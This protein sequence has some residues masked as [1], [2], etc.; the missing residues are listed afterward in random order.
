MKKLLRFL[1]LA[2]CVFC[3][4]AAFAG[5]K[6]GDNSAALGFSV[7]AVAFWALARACRSRPKAAEPAPRPAAPAAEVDALARVFSEGPQ[8]AL[9]A[10]RAL[11]ALESAPDAPSATREAVERAVPALVDRGMEDDLLSEEDEQAILDL[12]ELAGFTAESVGPAARESL[13]KA[14]L[15][16]DLLKG[17]VRARI[18]VGHLP[19]TL[20]KNETLIWCWPDVEARENKT[21]SEWQAG[22]QG[23]SLRVAKGVYWRV[24]AMK[25]RRV[26]RDVQQSL[27]RGPLAV[28][29]KFVYFKGDGAALRV[30][31]D[32]IISTQVY[33]DGVVLDLDGAR[34]RPLVFL[35]ED[36]W[37]MGNILNNARNWA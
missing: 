25:G 14:G 26:S 16:R 32:K 12:L 31:H 34:A 8:A 13:V 24:G 6:A 27:G 35:T 17:D 28:T 9:A 19:F 4:L 23:V 36:A 21:V 2:C 18:T 15:I 3:A 33:S 10:L 1:L 11:P 22:S 29:S 7:A 30:K 20:Q 37:F 5:F